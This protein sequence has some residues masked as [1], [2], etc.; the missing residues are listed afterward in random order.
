MSGL[1]FEKGPTTFPKLKHKNK[2]KIENKINNNCC[3]N[4]LLI[5]DKIF[6]PISEKNMSGLF[7]EKGPTTFW[8]IDKK[9]F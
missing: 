1:F 3:N 4:S 9:V 2:K 7:F 8:K 5:L 6:I